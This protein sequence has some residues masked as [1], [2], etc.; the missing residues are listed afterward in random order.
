MRFWD[1]AAALA[2]VFGGALGFA[3]AA[4]LN[5][6]P[7]QEF[8]TVAAAIAA[9]QNGDTVMVQAGTYTNDFAEIKVKITLQAAGGAVVMKASGFIPNHKAILIIDTDVSITGFTFTGAKVIVTAGA[10]GAGIRYQGGNLTVQ[11]CTFT[12]NQ[13]GLLAGDAPGTITITNSTFTSN[14]DLAG[15]GAGYTNNL[16]VGHITK[17]DIE[18]SAFGAVNLGREIESR[19]AETIINNSLVVDGPKGTGS[20]DIDIPNGG[21]LTIANT[22]I[23]KG[24]KSSLGGMIAY[25]E[26]G[27][28]A[29][30]LSFTMQN[31]TLVNDLTARPTWGVWNDAAVT[32][33]IS[34]TQVYGLS[35]TNLTNSGGGAGTYN[36]AGSVYLKS[37]PH[38]PTRIHK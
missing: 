2:S 1:T 14:G 24:P 33:N 6:G 32:A 19:A 8:S 3:H 11:N 15:P 18:S 21:V 13:A 23:E 29:P 25:G 36:V 31:N 22:I 10:N 17:L 38:I 37:R 12:H 26:Q 35:D 34:N 20:Y 4:T 27:S 30:T 5:V 9:A 7:A 16:Y 28:W